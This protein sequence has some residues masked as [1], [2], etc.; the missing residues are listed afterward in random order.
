MKAIN[1]KR[2]LL[3]LFQLLICMVLLHIILDNRASVQSDNSVSTQS[4]NN[5]SANFS[6]FNQV[7]LG[8]IDVYE[9]IIQRPLFV[10]TRSAVVEEPGQV[11]QK[12]G[13]PP[14]LLLIGVVITPE[15]KTA[16]L[17][18]TQSKEVVTLKSEEI[19]NG[20]KLSEIEDHRVVFVRDSQSHELL[21]EVKD[22]EKPLTKSQPRRR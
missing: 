10:M 12:N 1:K 16:L 3:L 21:L 15:T 13:K 9:S 19:F 4:G 14:P 17:S 22:T 8:S 2:L 7:A 20:W 18:N 6:V 11:E 5:I